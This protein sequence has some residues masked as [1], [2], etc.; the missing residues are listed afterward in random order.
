MTAGLNWIR[1]SQSAATRRKMFQRF[2]DSR[3]VLPFGDVTAGIAHCHFHFFDCV[4]WT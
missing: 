1:R 3:A 2:V 4:R